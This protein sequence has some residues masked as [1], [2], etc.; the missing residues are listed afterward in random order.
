MAMGWTADF[1]TK[2]RNAWLRRIT[3]AQYYTNGSWLTGAI[4][5]KEVSGVNLIIRFEATD[6]GSTSITKFRLIDEDGSVAYEVNVNIQRNT[7]RR[8][9][10]L[11]VVS[12]LTAT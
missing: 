1:L 4:T 8:G 2:R 5:T 6:G 9:A 12:A 11:E 10:L 3:I 7:S